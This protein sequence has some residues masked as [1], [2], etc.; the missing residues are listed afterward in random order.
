MES[1]GG[2]QVRRP[3]CAKNGSLIGEGNYESWLIWEGVKT[4]MAHF[5]A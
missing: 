4:K 5:L 3:M 2:S 1:K